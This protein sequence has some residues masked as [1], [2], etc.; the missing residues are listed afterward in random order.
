MVWRF[1]ACPYCY[2]GDLFWEDNDM[3]WECL[4]CSRHVEDE[5]TAN[6]ALRLAEERRRRGKTWAA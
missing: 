4:Q 5:E 2:G 6:T 3:W 1:K